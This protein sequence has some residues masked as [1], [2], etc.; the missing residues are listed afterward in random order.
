M[1]VAE[2]EP[3]PYIRDTLPI[4]AHRA[5]RVVMLRDGTV[6]FRPVY[7]S[8]GFASPF[9][10]DVHAACFAPEMRGRGNPSEER[11]EAPQADGGCSCGI[12]AVPADVDADHASYRTTVDLLVELYGRIVVHER[13]YRAGFA[14]VLE[15]RL[16]PCRASIPQRTLVAVA[17]GS[18]ACQNPV[19]T[20]GWSSK[21]QYGTRRMYDAR[22][23]EHDHLG[24]DFVWSRDEFAEAVTPVPV[25][26]M[27]S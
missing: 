16:L 26:D 17:S 4:L 3:L 19:T 23:D 11:H 15:C 9:L 20:F 2:P 6:R 25:S 24:V 7:A 5:A 18:V 27:P 12:Y 10:T 21:T 14:R 8:L 22:C 1:T 13:G